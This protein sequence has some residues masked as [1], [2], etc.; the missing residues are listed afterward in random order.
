MKL[1]L[2]PNKT[3]VRITTD[4]WLALQKSEKLTQKFWLSSTKTMSVSL[5]LAYANNFVQIDEG[6]LIYIDKTDFQKQKTKKDQ[7]WKL[8]I[9]KNFSISVE[10]DFMKVS[11]LNTETRKEA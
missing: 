11:N 8:E 7:A 9:D 3:T 5:Q 4:E 10:V 6:F 1:R 2:S